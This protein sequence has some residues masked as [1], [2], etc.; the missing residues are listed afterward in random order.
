MRALKAIL[1][2]AGHL[3]R[4]CENEPEDVICLRALMD[5]NMPKFTLIDTPLFVSI[6]NDLFPETHLP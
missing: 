1:T 4:Q 6:T 2:C 3:K 5:V